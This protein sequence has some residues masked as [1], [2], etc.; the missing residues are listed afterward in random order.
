MTEA[1]SI[2]SAE[3]Q[4]FSLEHGILSSSTGYT[5]KNTNPTIKAKSTR[6]WGRLALN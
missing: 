2:A 4:P 5:P 3:T 1:T 6:G